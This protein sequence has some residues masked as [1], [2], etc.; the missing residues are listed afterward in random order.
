MAKS[1]PTKLQRDGYGAVMGLDD[2]G[3]AMFGLDYVDFIRL[4]GVPLRKRQSIWIKVEK[5]KKSTRGSLKVTR[6]NGIVR[7]FF[8]DSADEF[9]Y[10]IALCPSEFKYRVGF[11]P[12]IRGTA[13]IRV[14]R[15]AAPKR[16]RNS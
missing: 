11:C 14:R 6:P 10:A 16:K 12:A 3:D 5:V 7:V 2:D 9:D 8:K 1:I 4:L 15:V 13:Y